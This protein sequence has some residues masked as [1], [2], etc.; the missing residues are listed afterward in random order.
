MRTDLEDACGC[1][2]ADQVIERASISWVHSP[3]S[4]RDGVGQERALGVAPFTL[5]PG[6]LKQSA[7][8]NRLC[9]QQGAGVASGFGQ[10][11]QPLLLTPHLYAALD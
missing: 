9:V 6:D 3:R 11:A 4:I 5:E 2:A 8:V 10:P 7:H 1:E